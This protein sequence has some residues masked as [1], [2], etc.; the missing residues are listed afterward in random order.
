MLVSTVNAWISAAYGLFARAQDVAARLKHQR[1]FLL[2][3]RALRVGFPVALIG[4]LGFALM[5][6]GWKEIQRALPSAWE[7]YLLLPVA[8]LVSPSAELLVY[9]R[10]WATRA[11][12]LPVLLRKALMNGH[13]VDLSGEAYLYVWAKRHLPLPDRFVLLSIKD[14]CLLASNASMWVF[15]TLLIGLVVS[16][17]WMISFIPDGLIWTCVAIATVP[18]FVALALVLMRRK[19]IVLSADQI[20]FGFV[21]HALKATTYHIV[22]VAMWAFAL[23]SVPLVVWLNFLAFRLLI[24]RLGFVPNGGLLVLTAGIGVAGTM[25]MPQAGVAA[26]LLTIAA[27]EYLLHLLCVGLPALAGS[28]RQLAPAR[29]AG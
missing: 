6:L 25:N 18:L 1:W 10:L 8:Y 28:F 16:G 15:F 20:T 22:L 24:A 12:T 23:P 5:T 7:F 26:V 11:L 4:Y 17:H 13:L 21:V 2:C 29:Q 3:L 19:L 27:S 9:R 14:N